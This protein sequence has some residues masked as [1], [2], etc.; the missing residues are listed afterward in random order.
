M[1]FRIKPIL[2]LLILSTLVLSFPG[3]SDTTDPQ[4]GASTNGTVSP[5][6]F[7][8]NLDWIHMA[9]YT[10]EY[11]DKLRDRSFRC[12][13]DVVNKVPAW[14]TFPPSDPE[15]E[16]VLDFDLDN[17]DDIVRTV[18]WMTAESGD[19]NPAGGKNYTGYVKLFQDTVGYTG[20]SQLVMGGVKSEQDY[21]IYFSSFGVDSDETAE[22]HL[23]TDLNIEP[24]TS[25]DFASVTVTNN[26]IWTQH[27]ITLTPSEDEPNPSLSI[28]LT[29][30]GTIKIDEVRMFR[31][32]SEPAIKTTL[33]TA[34]Q[35]LGVKS[36]RWPGGTLVDWFSWTDSIGP[37]LSRGELQAYN[38]YETPALGL[39]EFLDLCEE[40]NIE[41]FVM[42]NV[43]KTPED[44]VNL[45]EYI[46]GPSGSTQGAIRTANGRDNPWD[47]KYFEI[48]NEPVK[49]YGGG[50]VP[51]T[52]AYY[53]S[54]AT[55]II[56]AMKAKAESLGKTIRL[57]AISEPGFQ[58]ADWLVP[59]AINE[60]VDMLYNWN[61]QVFDPNTGVTNADFTNGH[62]YSSRYYTTNPE[63]HFR[64]AMTGGALLNQTIQTKIEAV[65][66]LPI[67][68]TEYNIVIVEK[69]NDKDFV[70]VEYLKDFQSGLAIA[71]ILMCIIE[72][73]LPGAHIYNLFDTNGFGIIKNPDTGLLRPG[74]L[75]FR[76]FSIMA[77]EELLDITIDNNST[78]TIATG[79][80]IVPSGFSYP[81]ITAIASK[82]SATKKTRIILLNRDY[83]NDITVTLVPEGFTPGEADLHR[84]E[85]NNLEAHNEDPDN[86]SVSII[87]ESI[88]IN[89]PFTITVPAHSL[90][91]IDFK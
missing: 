78:Y 25:L 88:I 73:K 7:G 4:P 50:S 71:D 74:G 16:P 13:T 29:S 1:K 39:H 40:L 65:T 55:A 68:L 19:P 53:A 41:P 48:G 82:N 63:D 62:F 45:I 80:E 22:V 67:W 79:K 70:H 69:I 31:T 47:V 6:I 89:N 77:N 46:L 27:C 60:T 44:A 83:S 32:I 52:G 9:A 5:F 91:R 24:V 49:N 81:I 61:S 10:M 42:V 87:T 35:N 34:I 85:N 54:Q 59:G 90:W 3:C 26:G 76:L 51:D 64:Y 75:V 17:D 15:M 23:Q 86:I 14:A 8:A 18:N 72:R 11:G 33:K 58:M 38:Y 57:G 66:S 20:I 28:Y 43:L 21:Q 12:K 37:I 36:L 30:P 2:Y 84:Y 56:T